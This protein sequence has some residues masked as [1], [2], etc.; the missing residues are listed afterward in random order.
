VRVH[1]K[2]RVCASEI[3]SECES[4]GLRESTA[5]EVKNEGE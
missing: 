2:V 4:D 5:S 1:V 3:E